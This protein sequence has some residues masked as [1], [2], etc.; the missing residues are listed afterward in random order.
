MLHLKNIKIDGDR[1]EAD[2]IPE[3]ETKTGHIVV[4]LP[5]EEIIQIQQVPGY[6]YMHPH[7]A[8]IT[9]VEMAKA[10]DNRTERTVIWY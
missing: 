1:A 3:T 6:E 5:S 4:D 7:H 2:F 9:L 10:Q 8:R